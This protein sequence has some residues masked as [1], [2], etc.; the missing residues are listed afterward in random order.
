MHRWKSK[1]SEAQG[2]G[3]GNASM[4]FPSFAAGTSSQKAKA[5]P[6]SCI[7]CGTDNMPRTKSLLQIGQLAADVWIC[8]EI[9]CQL[10]TCQRYNNGFYAVI[11]SILAGKTL[12]LGLWISFSGSL[13]ALA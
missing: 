12:V 8:L 5:G 2:R 9:Y 10:R 3:T 7:A 6:D 13:Y 11:K 1:W 4:T